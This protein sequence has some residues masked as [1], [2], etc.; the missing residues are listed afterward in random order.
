MRVTI[1]TC[2]HYLTLTADEVGDDTGAKCAPPI[3]DA[4]NRDRLWS[5]LGS[6]SIDLVVSDHSPCTGHLKEGGFD[7]AWGGIA[8]LELR[9][10]LMWTEARRRGFDIADLVRWT[11]T[12]PARLAGIPTGEFAPGMRADMVVWD[13]EAEITVQPSALAQRH[14]NTPYAGWRLRGKVAATIVRGGSRPGLLPEGT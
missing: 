12:Q 5:G 1:E 10:P 3:R 13:P 14:P 7:R 9:L 11:S 6:G 2:P 8:S 4:A